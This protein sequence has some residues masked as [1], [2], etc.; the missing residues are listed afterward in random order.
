[1]SDRFWYCL[2]RLTIDILS[3]EYDQ[4][5]PVNTNEYPWNW[6]R[7]FQFEENYSFLT[8]L[9][10]IWSGD[11][12]K[13]L[14]KVPTQKWRSNFELSSPPLRLNLSVPRAG[15]AVLMHGAICSSPSAIPSLPDWTPLPPHLCVLRRFAISADFLS[16]LL[17]ANKKMSTLFCFLKHKGLQGTGDTEF[18]I[19]ELKLRPLNNL[20][21][22]QSKTKVSF[23]E[24]GRIIC[25]PFVTMSPD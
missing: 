10:P 12:Y 6:F 16:R 20:S 9:L 11:P 24:V 7:E 13:V 25:R 14:G 3:G 19:Q 4:I 18:C 21:K 1:M 22:A 5:L 15:E 17:N 8:N 2:L 23:V